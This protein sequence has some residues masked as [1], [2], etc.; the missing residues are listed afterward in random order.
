MKCKSKSRQLLLY[1]GAPVVAFGL[2]AATTLPAAAAE[3]P[4]TEAVT[5]TVT[6]VGKKQTTPPAIKKEDVNLF[7]N[8]ERAQIA[9]LRRSDSLYLAILIDESLNRDVS[10]E[11]KDVKAFINAQSPDAYV[12]I[13]YARNGAA[14]VAQDFTNDHALAAKALRMPVN[15]AAAYTSPYLALQDWIKRWPDNGG[16][17]RS[18]ILLS[19]GIDYFRGSSDPINP[20]LDTTIQ[21]AQKQNIN[22]W[23]IYY[24]DQGQARVGRRGLTLFN[25]QMFLSQLSEQTGAESFQLFYNR[26]VSLKP[27]LDQIQ[28]RLNNQYLLTFDAGSGGKRGKF[29][30]VHVATE[31]PS[32]KFMS[33][34]EVYLPAAR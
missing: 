15:G 13:A 25:S 20:D 12:A 16:A 23:T 8:K 28:D 6:A 32:V 19:S 1:L 18:I 3:P 9:N 5:M 33:Q 31:I 21:R 29:E 27:Y 11:W 24:S 30:S 14:N 34:T 17:R 10:L 7:Q 22:V 2:L 26:P 4:A